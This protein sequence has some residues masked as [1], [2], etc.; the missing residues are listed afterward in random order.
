MKMFATEEAFMRQAGS[1]TGTNWSNVSKSQ[2]NHLV[3]TVT[4]G[5][6]HGRKVLHLQLGSHM[7]KAR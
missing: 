3:A 6:L 4:C 2:S 7:L 5:E 1:T